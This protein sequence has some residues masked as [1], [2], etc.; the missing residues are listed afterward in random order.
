MVKTMVSCRFSLKPIHWDKI[1]V[2]L[3]SLARSCASL[4]THSHHSHHIRPGEAWFTSAA[5][6]HPW[7]CWWVSSWLQ[8]RN[9]VKWRVCAGWIQVNPVRRV[10]YGWFICFIGMPCP[11]V[12]ETPP[13]ET[14]SFMDDFSSKK[15]RS[16]IAT[17]FFLILE[18]MLKVRLVHLLT[19]VTLC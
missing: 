16:S 7:T 10:G 1:C 13:S 17:F 15:G 5:T 4:V 8:N 18:G 12:T 14:G 19:V 6:P 9:L 2:R 11:A 3:S